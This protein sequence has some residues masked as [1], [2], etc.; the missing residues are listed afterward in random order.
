MTEPRP[1]DP[2]NPDGSAGWEALPPDGDP[3][4]DHEPGNQPEDEPGNQPE[5]DQP[6]DRP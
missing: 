1:E 3:S 5:D 6:A 2:P 4:A